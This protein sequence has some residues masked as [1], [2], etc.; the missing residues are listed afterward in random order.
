MVILHSK[1]FTSE[2]LNKKAHVRLLFKLAME[3]L[4]MCKRILYTHINEKLTKHS[5]S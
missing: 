4:L 5:K 2:F 1:C 3:S